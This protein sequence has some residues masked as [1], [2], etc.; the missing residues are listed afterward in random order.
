M[1]SSCKLL[2]VNEH[3]DFCEIFTETEGFLKHF[4]PNPYIPGTK[5]CYVYVPRI[6][7]MITS[8]YYFGRN[9]R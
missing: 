9:K 2:R 3:Q 8:I 5:Y 4:R 1:M 7:T 6:T